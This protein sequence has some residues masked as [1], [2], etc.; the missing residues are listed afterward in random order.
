M[1]VLELESLKKYLNGLHKMLASLKKDE[2]VESF[3]FAKLYVNEDELVVL[4]NAEVV[5]FAGT[6]IN[7]E[8]VDDLRSVET[9]VGVVVRDDESY[10]NALRAISIVANKY[11]LV[12]DENLDAEE[13]EAEDKIYHDGAETVKVIVYTPKTKTIVI[14]VPQV[15][16]TTV[17]RM[18][19][20][21]FTQKL[22]MVGGNE[23]DREY[24]ERVRRNFDALLDKFMTKNVR[25]R[26]TKKCVKFS[27][28]RETLCKMTIV[29]KKTIK[30]YLALNPFSY[31]DSYRITDCS[32][33]TSYQDVPLCFKVTGR[34]SLH[35]AYELIDEVFKANEIPENKKYVKNYP[36]SQE[37]V[38]AYKDSLKEKATA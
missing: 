6:S 13:I 15:R 34:V 7:V 20:L 25:Y 30:V 9:N 23:K 16:E 32:D 4:L 37:I 36:Y 12:I 26:I 33:K 22:V 3:T 5:D 17:T 31:E 10:A 18:V 38:K 27:Y 29:G 28:K 8:P 1:A 11:G 14:K 24:R 21:T 35:R 2:P 19:P